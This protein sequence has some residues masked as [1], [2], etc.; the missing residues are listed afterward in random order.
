MQRDARRGRIA[1]ACAAV[2]VLAACSGGSSDAPSSTRPAADATASTSTSTSTTA[3]P[4]TTTTVPPY[5]GWVDPASSGKPYGDVVDGL[6][7]FRGNPTR[8]YYGKGPVPEAPEVLWRYPRSSGMCGESSVGKE[9]KT[10]CGSGW[11]GEPAVFVRDGRTWVA[12]GAYDKEIH[13]LDGATGE[14]VL[15]GFDMGD[16]IKGSV[17]QDP[18]GLPLLYSGSRADFHVLAEDRPDGQPADLWSMSASDVSPTK[19]NN[20]WDSSP[21]VLDDY[22][23]EGGENGQWYVIKLNRQKGPDGLIAVDPVIQF[24]APGW[25]DQL[26]ADLAGS[27]SRQNDVSI[28]NSLAI[29]G[30]TVYFANSGGLVQGWDI[31]GVKEGRDPTRVF[32]F[33]TGDDTDA[34]V[35]IDAEGM[36]YVASERERASS[37]ARTDEAGQL[38]KLDPTKPDDPLVWS[39]KDPPSDPPSGGCE[40]AACYGIW[41]TPAIADGVVYAATNHGRFF[42]ASMET[43][44]IL[45][46]KELPSPTW[47]SPVVVDDTLIQGDCSGVL[48]AY[49]VSDPKA[50]PPERW[51]V[52]LEGCIES[53]PAVFDGRIYVGA[54]GG[55][56]Y[57]IGDA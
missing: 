33:W 54:R 47:Q 6:L 1:G 15:G 3:P 56:F 34:S 25:D 55:A 39:I 29:S 45:W 21:L 31:S 40:E 23:F 43:G 7:T 46:E 18:D 13:F 38:M 24:H 12:F 36:L 26:L 44:E 51:T 2:A 30:N 16:I 35:V 50:D 20:D 27:G 9:T 17:T 37:H 19:W 32:R 14:E 52:Q 48:H 4:S 28:E 49:D 57:A 8:S 42:G 11:T 5:E 53:T 10:W 22:L 41:G